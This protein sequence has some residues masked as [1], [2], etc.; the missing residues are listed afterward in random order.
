M[1]SRQHWR[2][3]ARA[4]GEGDAAGDA[5]VRPLGA[6]DLPLRRPEPARTRSS[7]S[8]CSGSR[9]S[10]P[11]C[12]ASRARSCPSAS[13]TD[14]RARARA[15]RPQRDLGREVDR[16]VRV[17]RR[18]PSSS[19]CPRSRSSSAASAG[20]TVA[21]V[22][23]ANVGIC[24]VGTLT[25]AM[26]VAGRARELILPLLFLPLAIPIVVGGVGASAG[27]AASTSPS[28]R[29]T[30]RVFVLLAWGSVRVRRRRD[31]T[32]SGV[33]ASRLQS[34]VSERAA[35]TAA[36]ARGRD[37]GP[38]RARD[39]ARSSSTRRPTPTRASRSGSS[40]STCRSR[41]PSYVCFA[42]GAWK[43]LLH[44][45]KR[46]PG[47]DLES[48][49][50]IHQGV[51]FGTLTLITGS[52]WAKISWG[53]W[54]VWGDN[55]LV[56]FLSCSSST[57]PTSC[58]ATRSTP[59]PQRENMCAVYA[60]FGVVLIPISFLAIRLAQSFIHPSVFTRHGPQMEHSQFLT[61]CVVLAHDARALRRR[62]T[63][64]SSPGKRLDARLREL[65]GAPR[66]EPMTPGPRSTPAA[67]YLVVFVGVLAY[68]L[69]I[70]SKLQRLEREVG[71]PRRE[72][73]RERNG[74]RCLRLL[75]WPA[76]IGYGEA[77][78]AYSSPRYTRARR[79]G[80]CASAGSPRPRC[81][82]CRRRAS[83]ASRG[84]RWAGSLNLF[85]WLVVGA[86]LIWGCRPRYRLLGLA[87]MPL[88]AAALPRRPPRRR[89][90]GRQALALRRTSS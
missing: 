34:A 78:L 71:E 5:A 76:L 3:V 66:A 39:R 51:I 25:G 1:S 26:A 15:V 61:F 90:G 46:T 64:S 79:P 49:V 18:S 55:Q 32:T 48:Y 7:R 86:Y 40:T 75:F 65:R 28:S 85:V 27:P 70:A 38:L 69:I 83:T 77:A 84:R 82:P 67:A 11:R 57:R 20:S 73:A 30:T 45:W 21:A 80:A 88:V 63:S 31:L 19:R 17:P 89:H 52:I 33:Y 23:L 2:A 10:S 9:S 50:A 81:S 59:G 12:S 53:V 14:G 60:L 72:L 16:R 87:V 41:S 22:A 62:S 6:D 74:R 24:A 54:W 43:A 56:L 47:A 29:S 58:C 36:G 13:R 42:W 68:V 37:R 35:D 44:L 8:A 4:A